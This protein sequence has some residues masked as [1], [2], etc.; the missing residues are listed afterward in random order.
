MKHPKP[1]NYL[2][3]VTLRLRL[4]WTRSLQKKALRKLVRERRRLSLLQALMEEQTVRVGS[5]M[6]EHHRHQLEQERR[7]HPLLT[8]PQQEIPPPSQQP[9]PMV[10]TPGSPV[11]QLPA[12]EQETELPRQLPELEIAQRLGL[13]QPQS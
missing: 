11:T 5:L 9:R 2:R 10:L 6:L 8:V 4:S 12:T 1:S 13:Q 7:S 3:L